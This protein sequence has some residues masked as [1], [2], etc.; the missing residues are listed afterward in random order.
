MA[1][2]APNKVA[3]E[4]AP[5]AAPQRAAHTP[6]N[7]HLNAVDWYLAPWRNL[8]PL[9][10]P[11]PKAFDQKAALKVLATLNPKGDFGGWKWER[12]GLSVAMSRP[13]AHFWFM[14]TTAPI[15]QKSQDTA[16]QLGKRAFDGSITPAA[17]RERLGEDYQPTDWSLLPLAN[18][19]PLTEVL[20]ILREG[21]S[22]ALG[23]PLQAYSTC[24]QFAERFAASLLPYLTAEEREELKPA[25]RPLINPRRWHNG[26]G[27]PVLETY[28]APMLGLSDEIVAV[29]SNMEDDHFAWYL[30]SGAWADP[31]RLLLGIADPRVMIHHAKRLRAPLQNEFTVRG[32]L[33]N[34]ELAGLD[35]IRDTIAG[36]TNKGKAEKLA[37]FLALVH[38]PEVAPVMLELQTGSKAA[39]P[40]RK[41]L[42]EHR[43]L[44]LQGLA[45]VAAGTGKAAEAAKRFLED[46]RRKSGGAVAGAAPHAPQPQTEAPIWLKEA[47]TEKVGKG[48]LPPWADP[49]V[50]PDVGPAGHTLGA[51]EVGHLLQALKGSTLDAPH[52]LVAALRQHGDKSR[53]DAFAWKLFELWQDAGF[54]SKEKWAFLAVGHFGGDVSATKLTPLVRAWPGVSQHAR[55]VTGLEVFRAINTDVA[56]VQLNGIAEKLKFQGLKATAQRFMDDIAKKRGLTTEQLGDRVVPALGLGPDGA[57]TFNYG[58]RAF[59]FGFD[60]AGKP[61]VFDANGAFKTDPPAPGKSDDAAL[62]K[63]ALDEWKTFKKQL[64]SVRDVQTTRLE[65]AMVAGRR[66][67]PAEFD[68]LFVR[69]PLMQHLVRR[70]LW[71]AH[72]SNSEGAS[73][74][75]VREDFTLAGADGAPFVL[76]PGASVELAHPLRMPVADRTTWSAAFG[77]DQLAQPFPQ[78]ARAAFTLTSAERQTTV[79]DRFATARFGARA[80]KSALEKGGWSRQN[81]DQGNIDW[82]NLYFPTA[83]VSASLEFEP[84]LLFSFDDTGPHAVPR[85]TFSSGRAGWG[86]GAPLPLDQVDPVVVSEVILFLTNIT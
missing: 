41:W 42:D 31:V 46:A 6:A 54:P 34:T 70:L 72:A 9:P 77:A 32:W 49:A 52:P 68:A 84:A 85:V 38:A 75:R 14:A 82:S 69:H 86:V 37:S 23:R 57:R 40:A 18:L 4:P 83:D 44:A 45:P 24:R 78:L 10:R 56:L 21:R 1:R 50:F 65:R 33:A 2:K 76:D 5:A 66:W 79:L 25:V 62:A 3:P 29:V 22:G 17:I 81:A 19:L 63:A 26:G 11:E 43:E 30:N 36:Q 35:V 7:I 71:A 61:G 47:L 74:F 12:A 15:G 60:K 13:E 48:V 27:E 80:L 67:A 16:N 39:A 58:P 55:A 28:I 59:R 73:F 53:L 20:A 8:P 51:V 64:K